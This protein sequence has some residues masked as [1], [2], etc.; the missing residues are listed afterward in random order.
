MNTPES[1]EWGEPPEWSNDTDMPQLISNVFSKLREEDLI[2]QL[3]KKTKTLSREELMRFGDRVIDLADRCGVKYY[4]VS[5]PF[6]QDDN[7]DYNTVSTNEKYIND[8]HPQIYLF[9]AQ[10]YRESILELE[11]ILNRPCTCIDPKN[12]HKYCSVNSSHKYSTIDAW[13]GNYNYDHIMA[14]PKRIRELAEE[15]DCTHKLFS[16]RKLFRQIIDWVCTGESL[17]W[18]APPR[19][20]KHFVETGLFDRRKDEFDVSDDAHVLFQRYVTIVE[21]ET[22]ERRKVNLLNRAFGMLRSFGTS[23]MYSIF[24]INDLST[25]SEIKIAFP[26]V[27]NQQSLNLLE[28]AI[29]QEYLQH[30]LNEDSGE[31]AWLYEGCRCTSARLVD[32]L[33]KH[34]IGCFDLHGADFSLIGISSR[35]LDVK[36]GCDK[37][38]YVYE[39][40]ISTNVITELLQDH[41]PF[42]LFE[43][44]VA[45]NKFLRK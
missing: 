7:D 34:V 31:W 2:E 18:F 5:V 4:G 23:D 20:R 39:S 1:E 40:M 25:K 45:I 13:F 12:S 33:D 17:G 42:S 43:N 28:D 8:N 9:P 30:K 44:I 27:R 11:N 29:N 3:I 26:Y 16:N 22:G 32:K 10:T 6:Y 41:C 21:S 38:Y 36:R 35:A 24:T 37:S 14:N 19:R 15:L